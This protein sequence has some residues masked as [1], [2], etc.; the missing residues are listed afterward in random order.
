MVSVPVML[1]YLAAGWS[2]NS[3]IFAPV[4][5]I[6]SV[7][8]PHADASTFWRDLENYNLYVTVRAN[9]VLG[10]GLGHGYIEAIRLPSIAGAYALYRF[11]PHNSILGLFAYAGGVGFAGL[12]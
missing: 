6:R 3:K 8:D 4:H 1:I 10:S 2:S 12:S 9:P 11:A 5:T 7:V